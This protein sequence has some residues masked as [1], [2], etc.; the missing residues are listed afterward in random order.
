MS[1]MSF[2]RMGA[3]SLS[4]ASVVSLV[5]VGLMAACD[6]N[7]DGPDRSLAAYVDTV[8]A[9]DAHAHPMA[10]VAPGQPADTDFDALPLDGLPPF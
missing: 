3:R 6:A 7:G 1:R 9:V 2:E 5:A 4:L 8:A 10:Y